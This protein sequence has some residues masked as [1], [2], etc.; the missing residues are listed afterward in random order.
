MLPE[1]AGSIFKTSSQFFTIRT[2]SKLANKLLI[3]FFALS[4][5]CFFILFFHPHKHAVLCKCSKLTDVVKMNFFI[6][7]L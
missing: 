5:Q 4:N 3:F 2:D 1:A 7:I 6:L